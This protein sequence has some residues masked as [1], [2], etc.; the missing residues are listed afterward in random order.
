M[1]KGL[2]GPLG[3]GT[4]HICVDMQNLFSAGSP[5][6]VPWLEEVLPAIVT[7]VEHAPER[8]IFTRFMTPE[9]P[10][11]ARGTWADLY[12][13]WP[14][15]TGTNLGHEYLDLVPTL[16]RFVPPARLLDKTCYSPWLGTG[17]HELVAR[18][19]IETLVV[20]GGETDVCVMATV[21]GAVD[22]GC[23]VVLATDAVCSTFNETHDAL[24]DLYERRFTHQVETATAAEIVDGWTVRD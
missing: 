8:T 19:A 6:A 24:L 16:A 22:R 11:L 14:E 2:K 23:R 20:S 13:A 17:L 10:D 9:S 15:V 21:L 18:S 5:W 12:R 1:G 3:N 7:I 4:V